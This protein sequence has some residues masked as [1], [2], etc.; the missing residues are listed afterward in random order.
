MPET[1]PITDEGLAALRAAWDAVLPHAGEYDPCPACL[2]PVG[3]PHEPGCDWER[4][5]HCGEQ[6]LCCGNCQGEIARN[7]LPGLLARID[8]AEMTLAA[9][10]LSDQ[11]DG[12]TIGAA[13][14]RVREL[15]TAGQQRG[16]LAAALERLFAYAGHHTS[17]AAADPD[18][19]G[20]PACTCGLDTDAALAR[21]ALGDPA[22]APRSSDRTQAEI[23]IVEAARDIIGGD[24]RL[25]GTRIGT[26]IIWRFHS[27]GA[28][29]ETINESYPHLTRQDILSAVAFEQGRRFGKSGRQIKH[30]VTT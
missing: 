1:T 30:G 23:G 25:A 7:A 15:E 22:P 3:R 6:S 10:I 17:C 18:A 9:V 14:A 11:A 26:E 8:R 24:P 20:H 29:I 2:T 28:S 5:P 27:S 4:C 19:A 16:D 13:K 12:P 21:A